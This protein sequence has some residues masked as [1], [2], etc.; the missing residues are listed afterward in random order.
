MTEEQIKEKLSTAF[1]SI[2]ANFKGYKVQIPEDTGG[3]DCSIT[4]DVAQSRNGKTRY[5][6]SGQYIELQLKS[7]EE[8]RVI[9]TT[10]HLKYD[11]E[12]KTYNDL[13]ERFEMGNAPL[14]LILAVLPDDR[15]SWAQINELDLNL[16]QRVYYFYPDSDM[17]VSENES[18]V[19]IQIPLENKI[20]IDFFQS[21]FEEH[22]N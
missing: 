15:E 4:F 16:A 14:V 19:R 20:D 17:E 21:I 11:L 22:Y 13:I 8:H 7:T 12:V 10:D 2:V 6:H 18:T 9:F 1:V 3:V 5:I